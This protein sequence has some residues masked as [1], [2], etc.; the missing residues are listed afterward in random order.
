MNKKI[1]WLILGS[2]LIILMVFASCS[3]TTTSSTTVVTT[4]S[5]PSTTTSVVTTTPT[6][7]LNNNPPIGSPPSGTPPGGSP[8]PGSPGG[9]APGGT[10]N[11]STVTGTAAYSQSGGIVSKSSQSITASGQDESAVKITDSGVY[12]LTDSTLSTTGDSSS[13]DGSS[14]YGLNAAVLAESGS[15]IRVSNVTITTTGSG[16]NGVFATGEGSTIDLTDVTISCSNTGA[17]GVDAT[18]SGTVNLNNVDITTAGNGASAAIATD[19]GGGTINVTGGTVTTTGSK[20]PPIYSTGTITVTDTNMKA[21]AS[22]AVAIEGK[23]SV[24]LTD[25]TISG[26][27]NWGVII[28]QSMSGDAAVGTGNFIMTGG[29]LTAEEGPLFYSTNT[30][31]IITLKGV[32]L[33]NPSGILL[34]ASAGDWGNAGSNGADVTFTADI[35]TLN[36]NIVCDGISTVSITLKNNTTLNG[37]INTEHTAKSVIMVLDS[38]SIWEVTGD[39]YISGLTDADATLANLHSNGHT[40]YYDSSN[41][42]NSWLNGKTYDLTGGGKLAPGA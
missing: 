9:S 39:S 33:V 3:A 34:K 36:G 16:A 25:T 23:N 38:T 21:A 20:S 35:E 19:R 18:L 40:I 37:A 27:R 42:T 22:E 41:S 15:K 26:A 30:Q 1:V 4:S 29:T 6:S 12:T 17:H 24:I 10:G 28:Y 7:T 13:M 5:S 2:L 11:S 32:T 31:A 8:S 14:F